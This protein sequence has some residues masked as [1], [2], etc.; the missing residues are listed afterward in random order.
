MTNSP[1]GLQGA[2][3]GVQL[4]TI[5]RTLANCRQK[6]KTWSSRHTEV[7]ESLAVNRMAAN[8]IPLKTTL[9]DRLGKKR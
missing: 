5:G 4:M 7:V 8:G 1:Q 6:A 3:T 2:L 9:P